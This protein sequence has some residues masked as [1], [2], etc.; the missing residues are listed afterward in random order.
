MALGRRNVERAREII[1]DGIDEVLHALVLEGGTAD[2]RDKLVG[3]GLAADAGLE[4]LG[5]DRLFLEEKRA[6]FLIEIGDGGDEIVVGV[7]DQRPYARRG[8]PRSR[9]SSP[10]S[11]SSR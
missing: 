5:R 8:S 6:D 7:V 10:S 2:D 1:D 9:R 3:D 4:H 11:S